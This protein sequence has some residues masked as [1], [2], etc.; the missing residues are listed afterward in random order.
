MTLTFA[1]EQALPQV[2]GYLIWSD[3]FKR[4]VDHLPWAWRGLREAVYEYFS[5]RP[6]PEVY[7]FIEFLATEITFRERVDFINQCNAVLEREMSGYRFVGTLITP[8]TSE[9]EIATIE[10]AIA[11]AEASNPLNPMGI[12]LRQALTSLADRHTPDFRNSMKESISAVEALC[13][14]IA[15][16]ANATLGVALDKT[17]RQGAV[18]MHSALK[19]AFKIIVWLYERRIWHSPCAQR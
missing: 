7:D 3:Y 4:P 14:L 11:A 16:D 19:A 13:K 1:M 17:A 12:H 15:S 8:I 9:Q 6:W 5:Q 2:Y 10:Q 18:P